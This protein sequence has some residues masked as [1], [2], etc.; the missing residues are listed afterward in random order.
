MDGKKKKR[1]GSQKQLKKSYNDA[2]KVAQTY[3]LDGDVEEAKNKYEIVLQI[4]KQLGGNT[5]KIRK[6]INKLGEAIT[7]R[8]RKYDKKFWT[9]EN[10]EEENNEIQYI[11]KKLYENLYPHQKLVWLG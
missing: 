9:L 2:L 4:C 1:K 10:D 11:N 6:K 7:K 5:E 8:K 3:D